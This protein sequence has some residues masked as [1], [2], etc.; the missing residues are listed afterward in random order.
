MEETD[1]VRRFI[2]ILLLLT[3]ITSGGGC[4]AAVPLLV[5]PLA[6]GALVGAGAGALSVGFVY[7]IQKEQVVR[8][9]QAAEAMYK[10]QPGQGE[11]VIIEAVEV[12]PNTVTNGDEVAF[13]A[14]FTL[15]TGND[16]LVPVEINQ[17]IMYQGQRM[18]QPFTDK[19]NRK[20]GSY[21]VSYS[22]KIPANAQ[23]GKYALVT[24]IKTANAMD[25]KTCEFLVAKKAACNQR[26]I[27]LVSLNGV[28]VNN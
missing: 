16:Q 4:I 8:D 7:A 22:T 14:N 12:A 10:Y 20:S 17:E 13:N 25:E 9:R 11:R 23:P 27:R 1:M 5:A 21:G 2:G 28:P 6:S 24:R 19:G 3:F 18:G 15:L 26:E